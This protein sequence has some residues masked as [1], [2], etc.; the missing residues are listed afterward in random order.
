MSKSLVPIETPVTRR[1]HRA[2]YIAIAAL[3]GW[4]MLSVWA[5]AGSG[6]TDYL[7]FIV[8]GFVVMAVGLPFVLSRVNRSGGS[9]TRELDDRP[10]RDWA[11]AD[12][13]TWQG[14]LRG[15]HAAV[16]ILLPIAAVAFGMTIF[17]VVL[18][19]V[20]HGQA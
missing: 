8:C 19:L 10:W 7:L 4:L 17:G 1:L 11:A 9:A 12:F 5:F 18:R 13:D 20:A 6:V 16:Q 14:R 2:V 3:A 15:T